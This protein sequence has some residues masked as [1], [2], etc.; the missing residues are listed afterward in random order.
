M[1]YSVETGQLSRRLRQELGSIAA[2]VLDE[3]T[4]NAIQAGAG[5]PEA[6]LVAPQV[7]D[8]TD[9]VVYNEGDFPAPVPQGHSVEL[10]VGAHNDGASTIA[11]SVT[12][13]VTDPDGIIRDD[14]ARIF[15]ELPAG[16]TLRARSHSITINK[17]GTWV[18]YALLETA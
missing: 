8:E 17:Q 4:W 1:D 14:V 2:T 7:K 11:V 18:F 12:I 3:R 13:I 9:G 5:A 15:P 16:S 6:H 10:S